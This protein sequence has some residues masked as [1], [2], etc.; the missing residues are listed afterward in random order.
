MK[1]PRIKRSYLGFII[2][3]GTM[4]ILLFILVAAVTIFL[5]T[6]QLNAAESVDDSLL[7]GQPNPLNVRQVDP[8]LALVALGGTP[9]A[10]VISESIETSRPETALAALLFS[11]G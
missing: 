10:D 11:R 6:S 2:I 8:A 5:L 4:T 7:T 1:Q 9:D 3:V